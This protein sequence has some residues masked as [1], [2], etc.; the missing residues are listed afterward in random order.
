[1]LNHTV[2]A[3]RKLSTLEMMY[4]GQTFGPTAWR[5]REI[6]PSVSRTTLLASKQKKT[7]TLEGT[8]SQPHQTADSNSHEVVKEEEAKNSAAVPDLHAWVTSHHAAFTDDEAGS[9]CSGCTGSAVQQWPDAARARLQDEAR[10]ASN[11][12]IMCR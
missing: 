1:V 10:I 5:Y 7:V 11:L 6:A 3:I 4:C 2:V 9:I 8:I 12:S